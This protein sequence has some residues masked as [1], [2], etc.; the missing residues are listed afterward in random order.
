VYYD[1]GTSS[2][3]V[4]AAPAGA[5]GGGGTASLIQ[6]PTAPLNPTANTLWWDEVSGR[7]Y[8][9][10]DDGTSSQWVDAS[11]AGAG[12]NINL[13]NVSS[14]IIPSAN[15]VYSLGNA[16]RQ[17][18]DLWVSGNTIYIGSVPL[19]ITGTT[20]QINGSNVVTTTGNSNISVV[21][22]V[23]ADYFIG[24]GSQ[25][26]NLP[27]SNT[28]WAN[29]ANIN[30]ANGPLAILIG[31]N[32]G[33]QSSAYNLAIGAGA[34]TG[35]QGDY[36]IAIGTQAGQGQGDYTL[37]IGQGAGYAQQQSATAVGYG[38]GGRQGANAVAVG[39][40]AGGNTQGTS[41]VAIGINAGFIG[42]GANSIAIG[43]R[44]GYTNQA[45]NSII[46]N[47]T[48]ANLNQTTA[49]TFTVA[50]VRND[51]GNVTNALYYNTTTAEISYGPA[52]AGGSANII[53]N[54]LSNVSVP[55]ANGNVY[56][57]ANA[58]VDSQWTFGTDGNLTLPL[59]GDLNLNNG[60]I[61]QSSNDDLLITAID[62]QQD[63]SSSL[64]MS[65]GDTLTRL[66]QWSS[67]NSESFNTADWST[68]VY[69]NQGGLGA[70]QFTGAANIVDFVNSVFGATGHIFISVNGGPLLFLDGTGGGATDITFY[71]PT[72]P[73]VNPTTV[74]SF[75]Y[76]YSY[77][78][79]FEIDYD[80]NEV[81]I[82]AN[83]TDITLLTTG[84]RDI[85]L[86]SSGEVTITANSAST[87]TFGT[88][89]SLTLPIGVSIDNSVSPV[90]PKIIAD[91]DLLFSVQGQGANG[92]AAL[93]W[94]LDPNTDTQYAAV[95]VNRGGGDDLAKVVL[96]AGNT[97]PTLKVW[98][99][100]ETGNLTLP[101]NTFAVNYANGTPVSISGSTANT[102][103]VTF[104][105]QIVIGTGISNLVSGLYLA[106]SSSSA[107]AVQYLRVRGD[108][109]YE[110]THIHFDTGNNQYFN[111]F[112]GDDNKYVLLSNTGNIV[113]NTDNY[114]GNSAQWTF[115]VDGVLTLPNADATG[116][117]N[118]YFEEN[119]STI[120]FGLD[121]NATPYL[122]SFSTS[123]IT[124]PKGGVVSEGT[125][126]SGLGNTIA[127]TPSGG[128]DA[129]QQ[130]LVYP[131]GNI[132]EGNHLH[133]TTGDLYNTELFLGNDNLYVK[134]ANTGNIVVNSN[135]G[136]GNTAQWT[137]GADGNLTLPAT[138]G[139]GTIQTANAY[140]TLLAY[141]SG[142][143]LGSHGGPELDWMD[144]DDPANTFNSSNTVRNTLYLNGA[145]LYV[146]FNENSNVGPYTGSFQVNLL[147]N[148]QIPTQNVG[149][150]TPNGTP[151]ES[152]LLRGTRKA[153]N[154]VYSGATNP[155]AVEIA[156]GTASTVAY[157]ATNSNVQSVRVTFAVQSTGNG[158]CWEQ[159]DVVAT[160]SQDNPGTVNYVVSNR[161]KSTSTVTDTQV[162]VA[163]NGGGQIEISLTPMSGQNGW[164]SFDAVE[165]GLMV[166]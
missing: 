87:W 90:Y 140:P 79:G 116:F 56:I 126:P 76:F 64:L 151:G 124:L 147:G 135:D 30:N 35:Y 155:F 34:G 44:A 67:Q 11:P 91:S 38:A 52:G 86:D 150:S 110:P 59:N 7:L 108:T 125:A 166:D 36:A 136:T 123:G 41:A 62:A 16:T 80:S 65:P 131:T 85:S 49:N 143:I 78:S 97:T 66:E 88:D 3:W 42:Q 100:D 96:T 98:K 104:S 58:S 95:G 70:V 142:G 1:D 114:V 39:Y 48:G 122:Y 47:A 28:T 83:D 111:Q 161:I 19:T 10:Y 23:T 133:L 119:S 145:G 112:I 43:A 77:K 144:S 152:Q 55:V 89:G 26:T 156:A 160:P 159:F 33:N 50:P 139:Q 24:N 149:A 9:Y 141:G 165:F 25:L 60:G 163:L 4:D 109:S 68:G 27:S 2:Q 15:L 45:N 107:N 128:S 31:Q 17:W 118:I 6:S 57:N 40:T 102:G 158:Y 132:V 115:G 14:D 18:K 153:V 21:G 101:G 134:L 5:G 92:S 74:T 103:N 154:G 73:A 20:L 29:I 84:Q 53:Y 162:T 22:N 61:V 51:T 105:D 117:G 106:P 13:T 71:T 37:A 121:D 127:I 157:T 137:F 120:T 12:G 46:L 72:L 32:A 146:G 93:A 8:V 99:F 129:N 130:L 81:N 63:I 113:I 69:T 82:Y 94:S 164:A 75:E 148:V 138:N 54:G